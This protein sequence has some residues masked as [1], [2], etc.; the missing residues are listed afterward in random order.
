MRELLRAGRRAVE[1]VLVASERD[2][3]EVVDEIVR[4]ARSRDVPVRFAS[5][6]ELAREARTD[7]HQG[8]IARAAPLVA[9]EL[10]RLTEG[11]T[12]FLVALDG[13]TDPHNLGAVLRSALGAGVT[14]IVLGQHRAVHVTPTVAKAAAGAIEHLPIAVVPGLPAALSRLSSRGVWT[15]GLDADAE[16]SLEEVAVFDVPV[17]LVFGAEGRGL[18]A[19]TR[20]RCEVVAGIPLKGPLDSLNVSAAAAVACFTV[21]RVRARPGP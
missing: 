13:V 11:P 8:V 6:E 12:P 18:G 10:D 4:L 7:A 15:V 19:L 5:T 17:A 2:R 3:S 21:A 1:G 16:Q 14:G 9:V 20:A